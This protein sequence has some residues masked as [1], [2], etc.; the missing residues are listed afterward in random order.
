MENFFP[1]IFLFFSV[2]AFSHEGHNK[3]PGSLAA[4]HGGQIKGTSQL[5]L[6]VV[7]EASAVKIYP[8]DHDMKPVPLNEIK[9]DAT[10]KLPKQ[11][12]SE[13][14]IM[15][16]SETFFEAKIDSKG[17]HRYNLDLKIDY[18]QKS[19]KISFNVEPQ[20]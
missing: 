19:E 2:E 7:P 8:F 13:K 5:Y 1:F 14:V 15:N 17:S 18:K 20:E 16:S 9:I 3:T 11:K 6:E 4:P 12:K 10:M